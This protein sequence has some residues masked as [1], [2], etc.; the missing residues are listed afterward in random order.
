MNEKGYL[1]VPTTKE[2]WIEIADKFEMRWNF[3]NCVGAI[4]G[5]HIVMQA[6]ACSGSYYYNYKK[7]H[8]IVLM[9]V[10]NANYEFI[11]VDIGDSGRQ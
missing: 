9:A 11:L 2:E 1:K 4:N 8:S 6:P 10:V 3:P 5:K 7:C